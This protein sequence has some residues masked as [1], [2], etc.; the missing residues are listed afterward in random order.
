MSTFCTISKNLNLKQCLQNRFS[1][2]FFFCAKPHVESGFKHIHFPDL[3]WSQFLQVLLK[4]SSFCVFLFLIS[5]SSSQ[6]SL[7]RYML[8]FAS[9]TC[10]ALVVVPPFTTTIHYTISLQRRLW[11]GMTHAL[12]RKGYKVCCNFI[13]V[14]I[15]FLKKAKYTW[16]TEKPE[17]LCCL[18]LKAL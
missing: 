16:Q 9:V 11:S 8:A 4:K 5:Y 6:R 18:P 14:T 12:L 13:C 15:F 2:F 10:L 17:M 1:F 7:Y 3:S